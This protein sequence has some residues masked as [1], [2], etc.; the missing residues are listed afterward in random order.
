MVP[1]PAPAPI[2]SRWPRPV[3]R[4]R[5]RAT[6]QLEA[7][8]PPPHLNSKQFTT[9]VRWATNFG[10]V[11]TGETYA[12][13]VR[14]LVASLV[15]SPDYSAGD[16]I[17]TVRGTAP[18][19]LGDRHVQRAHAQLRLLQVGDL[20]VAVPAELGVDDLVVQLEDRVD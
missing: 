13:L 17:R 5:R 20:P 14:G 2:T 15:R 12:T 18:S 4:G 16:V 11:T 8:G 9:R 10:G 7:I 6:R 1:P 19:L 3:Q